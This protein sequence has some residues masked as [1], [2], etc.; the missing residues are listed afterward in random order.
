MRGVSEMTA[1][2]PA[3]SFAT[4]SVFI[5]GLEEIAAFIFVAELAG[6]EPLCKREE[7]LRACV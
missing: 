3:W 7:G 1:T 5:S 2:R 4:A 6:L